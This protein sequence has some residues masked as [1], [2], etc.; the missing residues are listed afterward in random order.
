MTSAIFDE[1]I[2]SRTRYHWRKRNYFTKKN[3]KKTAFLL[4]N[5]RIKVALLNGEVIAG[6]F[7]I[8]EDNTI[9]I[10]NRTISLDSIAKIKRRSTVSALFSP[11]VVICGVVYIVAGFAGIAAGGYAVLL[12]PLI[13]VGVGMILIATISENHNYLKWNY[14]I[15]VNPKKIITVAK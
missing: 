4:E 10:K 2:F 9:I 7:K 15:G 14:S 8:I 11:V 1:F 12:A 5:K 13:P 6:K 3:S